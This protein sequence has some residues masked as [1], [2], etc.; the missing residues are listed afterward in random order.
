MHSV[1]IN[2]YLPNQTIEWI[3]QQLA[4]ENVDL[5]TLRGGDIL[6]DGLRLHF[7]VYLRARQIVRAYYVSGQELVLS[8][9]LMPNR[10]YQL[11]E[12]RNSYLAEILRAN[13]AHQESY[14]GQPI[15]E[16]IFTPDFQDLVGDEN[17]ADHINNGIIP[18][19]KDLAPPDNEQ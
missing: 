18:E 12:E 16:M 1:D 5:L 8:V 11:V 2:E 4:L 17:W 3:T 13:C 6:A 7:Q 10:G 9:S 19:D 14:E 15:R